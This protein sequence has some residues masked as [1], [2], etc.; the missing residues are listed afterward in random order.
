VTIVEEFHSMSNSRNQAEFANRGH[1][2]Q[3]FVKFWCSTTNER[4]WAK[5]FNILRIPGASGP[6]SLPLVIE[7][8][9]VPHLT[10]CVTVRRLGHCR[11]IPDEPPSKQR[12]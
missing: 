6:V 9:K 12:N 7:E 4:N 8:S 10:G 2:R 3:T 5:R 1:S 11:R